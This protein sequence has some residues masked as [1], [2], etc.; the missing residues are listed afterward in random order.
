MNLTEDLNK[1]NLACDEIFNGKYILID[2]KLNKLLSVILNSAPLTS[3]VNHCLK[4]YDFESNLS[5][6]LSKHIATNLQL[7][8]NDNEIVAFCFNLIQKICKKEIDFHDFTSRF[9][10]SNE[11]NGENEFN[12]FIDKIIKPFQN[13]VN[14][15]YKTLLI[16]N[17]K[18]ELEN[19]MFQK[20]IEQIHLIV[21]QV[22]SYHLNPLEKDEFLTLLNSLYLSC[23][24]NDKKMVFAILIGVD[25]FTKC[26]KKTRSA[27]NILKETFD[28]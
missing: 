24:N 11:Q 2:L 13:S 28:R 15:F 17:A 23:K 12:N 22:D 14:N 19:S 27:Y 16:E 5:S 3:I 21:N 26:H 4:A 8:E 25:Y 1:F 7:P 10:A 18:N 6:L 9:F 20:L